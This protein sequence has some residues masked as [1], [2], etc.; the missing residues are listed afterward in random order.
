MKKAV[1][2]KAAVL[3]V[4]LAAFLGQLVQA[5]QGESGSSK[6]SSLSIRFT[7]GSKVQFFKNS[8]FFLNAPEYMRYIPIHPNDWHAHELDNAPIENG[9]T[10]FPNAL[11]IPLYGEL[12][13]Q[14]SFS[15]IKMRFKT[16]MSLELMNIVYPLVGLI[17]HPF[18]GIPQMNMKE[19]DYLLNPGS[20][21]RG[22]GTALTYYR[23]Y[24]QL[25]RKFPH[26][27][28]A[29]IEI[30]IKEKEVLSLLL[31]WEE[32]AS[33]DLFLENGW[34]R[35]DSLQV[36]ETFLLGNFSPR[37]F[38]TGL[39]W[40]SDKYTEKERHIYVMGYIIAG[41]TIE[42]RKI[43]IGEVEYKRMPVFF[44]IGANIIFCPG[45]F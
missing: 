40:E 39:I 25:K 33:Y 29:E 31:G 21:K 15:N 37:K 36:R 45:L 11:S 43:A 34:D 14:I 3:L 28:G 13:P 44:Q 30:G 42:K 5:K 32:I 1:F 38:Y 35:Y 7:L 24:T 12:G 26:Y 22:Y 27:Y 9:I 18:D 8:T 20:S 41:V 17:S 2:S 16:G 23:V 4:I 6:K 10:I 19:R